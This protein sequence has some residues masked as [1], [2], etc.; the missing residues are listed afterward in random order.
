[1]EA[2]DL[3]YANLSDRL[4]TFKAENVTESAAFLRWFLENIFRLDDVEAID[5]ICDGPGDLGIDGIYVDH[6]LQVVTI[7]QSKIRQNDN[8]TIGD[9]PIREFAG[10]VSQFS[11]PDM[12]AA[13]KERT[14]SEDLKKLIIRQ[15]IEDL[16][17]DGYAINGLFVTNSILNADAQSCA[18]DLHIDWYDRNRIADEYIEL[19]APSGIDG[20]ANFD[21]SD[22]EPLMFMAGADAKVYLLPAK[23]G[24]IYLTHA[25][26]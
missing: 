23:A 17:R 20:W 10:S 5:S 19:N 26:Q 7:L 16:V 4:R 25:N 9:T 1:M 24:I 14:Q 22:I 21:I 2:S 15:K 11:D 3:E 18:K 13:A 6:D 8:R 12:I